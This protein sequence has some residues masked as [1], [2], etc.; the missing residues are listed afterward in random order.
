M[1]RYRKDVLTDPEYTADE[2]IEPDDLPIGK[3]GDDEQFDAFVANWQ[4]L[5]RLGRR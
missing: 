2:P 4:A 3:K 1:G 5:P